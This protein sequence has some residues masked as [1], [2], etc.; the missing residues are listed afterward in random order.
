MNVPEAVAPAVTGPPA[1]DAR[2]PAVSVVIPARDAEATIV[3]AIDSVLAQDYPGPVEVIVADGSDTSG[4]SDLVRRRFPEALVVANLRRN[5]AAG[6]NAGIRVARAR[7]VARCD[8]HAV[9]PS[10]YLRRAV[11][12]L[13]RTGAANVGGR[14]RPA[15]RTCFERAVGLAMTIGLGAGDARYRLGGPEGPV[16]TVP[17]GVFRRDA[18][19]AVGGFDPAMA[20]NEDYELNWRLRERGET[21]WFDP[22]LAVGYRPRGSLVRLARQY[23]GYGRWKLVMLRRHPASLRVRQLAAPALVLGLTVSPVLAW[24]STAGAV[25]AAALPAVWLLALVLG[26]VAAGVRRRE[27]AAVLAP[28]ALAAMHLGWGAG[29]W[30]SFVIEART[31]SGR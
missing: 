25:A 3:E 13:G 21:V 22:L 15:G 2:A 11:E 30:L 31:R 16:D 27:P 12:T 17:F 9:L 26:S 1:G 23:Y 19:D 6:L 7:I 4:T 14:L 28:L 18:L 5:A 24:T 8:A 10:G 20:R 29:F